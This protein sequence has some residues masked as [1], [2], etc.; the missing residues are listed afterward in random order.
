VREVEWSLK[1]TFIYRIS[2]SIKHWINSIY[3]CQIR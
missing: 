1:L 2:Q 3:F